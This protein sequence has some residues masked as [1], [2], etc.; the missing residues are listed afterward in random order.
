MEPLIRRE[1]ELQLFAI[2]SLDD[3]QSLARKH[4]QLLFILARPFLA[5]APSPQ[6]HA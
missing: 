2:R 6:I 1:L 5:G 3:C 4:A